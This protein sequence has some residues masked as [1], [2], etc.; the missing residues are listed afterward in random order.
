MRLVRQIAFIM[1]ILYLSTTE[2]VMLSQQTKSQAVDLG[3]S[4]M[5]RICAALFALLF[6][7]FMLYSTVFSHSEIL[8]NAAHDTRHAITAPCH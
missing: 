1:A 5:N 8:H 6:G 3:I 4:D 2:V 7:S